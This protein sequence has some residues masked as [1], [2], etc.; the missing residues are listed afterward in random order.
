MSFLLK[1]EN[2][3][4]S[5]KILISAETF[6]L[7]S[8][9][10]SRTHDQKKQSETLLKQHCSIT[11]TTALSAL[12][13]HVHISKLQRPRDNGNIYSTWGNR[14]ITVFEVLKYYG[15]YNYI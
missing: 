2:I 12:H 13:V 11:L 3:A 10:R 4:K 15:N 5:S 9:D 14:Y 1:I 8:K 6:F 7:C